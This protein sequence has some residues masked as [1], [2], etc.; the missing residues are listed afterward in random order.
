[1]GG[2]HPIPFTNKICNK[3][4]HVVHLYR[5]AK[6]SNET[7]ERNLATTLL[8]SQISQVL[9]PDTSAHSKFVEKINH[10]R[11]VAPFHIPTLYF[12]QFL[13]AS[14]K[15]KWYVKGWQLNSGIK[16]R[17]SLSLNHVTKSILVFLRSV[18]N[19]T[20][21]KKRAH[22]RINC[23]IIDHWLEGPILPQIHFLWTMMIQSISIECS[24]SL[25]GCFVFLSQM[26]ELSQSTRKDN[27][28][29]AN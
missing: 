4:R 10:L 29:V 1:M 6:R 18:K 5:I 13:V 2:T 16:P 19:G 7:N 12:L 9:A 8:T 14:E 15:G 26:Y 3:K 11:K 27:T 24:F 25:W 28:F 23:H 20:K 22:H 21:R 17:I